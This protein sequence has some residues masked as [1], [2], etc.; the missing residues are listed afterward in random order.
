MSGVLTW[1]GRPQ[2]GPLRYEGR[3]YR[4]PSEA[5]A[6]MEALTASR[7]KIFVFLYAVIT[8]VVIF[9]SLMYLVEGPQRGFTSIPRGVYWGIVTLTTVGYGDIAPKTVPGQMPRPE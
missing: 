7:R 9:G 6:L 8:L 2:E 1:G 4:P 5:D 3:M